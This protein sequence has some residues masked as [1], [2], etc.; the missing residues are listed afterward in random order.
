MA[1]MKQIANLAGV[2]LGTVDRVLNNRGVVSEE[3]RK[4]ILDIAESLNYIPNRTAR[5]LAIRKANIKIGCIIIPASFNGIYGQF[6]DAL[7]KKAAEL[8]DYN[9][10]VIVKH[11]DSDNPPSQ[12]KLLDEMCD[13]GVNGIVFYGFN[14]VETVW[15]IDEIIEKGIPVITAGNDLPDSK[16]I[17]YV[18]S[19][20]G[21]SGRMA[22]ELI[23][24]ICGENS[25]VGV[26]FY[27]LQNNLNYVKRVDGLKEYIKER[28]PNMVVAA[29]VPNYSDDFISYSTVE[30]I[31]RDDPEINSL[32][33]V[34]G[35]IYGACKAVER[36]PK[37]KRPKVFCYNCIPTT[38]EMLHKGIITATI[39]PNPVYQ[40]TKP[41]D[42]MFN[43]LCFGSQPAD[44]FFYA[45]MDIIISESLC[46]E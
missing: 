8:E 34:S 29:H 41:L 25:K 35:G 43:L 13:E 20:F 4:S 32:L 6:E 11:I 46:S 26:I 15:K 38:K 27:G 28:A 31:M 22:G 12:N 33:I 21:K 14:L 10:S 30:K 9:I 42:L 5:C 7:L 2:S 19:D 36:M 24:L 39:S 17:A 37:G 44:T 23:K 40:G 18:G 1:T 16:R 3:T 45:D